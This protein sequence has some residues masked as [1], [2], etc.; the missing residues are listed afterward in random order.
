M[1]I[2]IINKKNKGFSLMEVIVAVAIITTTLITIISLVNFSVSS[3]GVGESTI[4]A[5]SLAQEGLEIVRNI[6]D[7]N[8]LLYKRAPDNWR[9][10]LGEGDWRVQ[11]DQLG[12][13]SFSNTPLKID[14]NGFYQY[15]SGDDTLFYRKITIEYIPGDDT[16]IKV[17]SEVTWQE[18]SRSRNLIAE[19]RLYNWLE[20]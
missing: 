5:V 16:Q 12:L 6:R 2:K 13:F 9:D 1:K 8:W 4:T 10:D 18:K 7:N 17:I 3:V 14:S 20:E 15:N 19:D 11:Y